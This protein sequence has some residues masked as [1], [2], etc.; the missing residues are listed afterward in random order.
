M[1]NFM[2]LDNLKDIN[3]IDPKN[4]Y[5]ENGVILGKNITIY[6]NNYILGNTKIGDNTTLLPFNIIENCK[7]GSNVK[8]SFSKLE[9]SQIN[10]NV[11]IGPF[12]HLRPNSKIDADCKIGN[13]VEIK[14]S[15]LGVGT[16]ASHL[17]YVG[18]AEIGNDCNIG[19]GAIFVNYN[20][21]QK[22]KTKVGN[23][24]FIGSNANLIAPINVSDNSY[25][26]AGSTLTI[27]TNKNDFVIARVRE[28]IKPNKATKYL[29][30]K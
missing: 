27:D 15:T 16:K 29:K 22:Q 5:I 7:I 24:C 23:N 2:N 18:D 28:T 30:K 17:A 8:I 19:C 13:F 12:A 6:P 4:T 10:N 1:N 26:C 9:D 21:T 3:I 20:G 14:N 11:T 25:I